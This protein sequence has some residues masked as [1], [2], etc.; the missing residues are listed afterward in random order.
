MRKEVLK[1]ESAFKMPTMRQ[2]TK[3]FNVSL[4]TVTRAI[5]ALEA[6]KVVVCRHGSGIVA[7]RESCAKANFPGQDR[8]TEKGSIVLA[9]VDYP[10]DN[11][12]NRVF[13]TEQYAH[14]NGYKVVNCKIHQDTRPIEIIDFVKQQ[15]DCSGLVLMPS[16]MQFSDEEVESFAQLAMPVVFV[17]SMFEYENLPE[18]IYMVGPDPES[19]G[20]LAIEHL[21]LKGHRN[22]GLIRNEPATEY[23]EKYIKTAS[24]F[25]KQA[26]EKAKLHYFPSIIRNWGN[27][28]E[29]ARRITH[30]NLDKIRKL[31]ITALIYLS[32]KGAFASLPVLKEAGFKIP[33]DISIIASADAWFCK[34]SEPAITATI[35]DCKAMCLQAVNIINDK[36]FRKKQYFKVKEKLTKRSSVKQK[37]IRQNAE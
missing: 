5:K 4:V 17:H 16:A 23:I 25:L 14:Q 2:L 33:E 18:N 9:V 21:Y 36:K 7:A 13:M 35:V 26:E 28:M 22:I 10:S 11:I 8:T 20:K 12:W 1:P 19:A 6:E 30:K 32:S 3:R 37:N 24:E 29:E 15:T 31:K 27:A 34:Y